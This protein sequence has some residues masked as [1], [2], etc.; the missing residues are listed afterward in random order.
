M[1]NHIFSYLAKRYGYQDVF[2]YAHKPLDFTHEVRKMATQ[3]NRK[4]GGRPKAEA[5]RERR[6]IIRLTESEYWH[7]DFESKICGTNK[8]EYMRQLLMNTKPRERL[9]EKQHEG[10]INLTNYKTAFSRAANLFKKEGV[11]NEYIF[12]IRHVAQQIKD[13]LISLR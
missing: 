12:E 10:I 8:S 1:V 11:T 6:I 3:Q 2:M 7:L 13:F 5:P 4:K 9:T